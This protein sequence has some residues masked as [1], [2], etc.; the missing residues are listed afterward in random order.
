MGIKDEAPAPDRIR[1]A[2]DHRDAEAG[3]GGKVPPLKRAI[4]SDSI[5]SRTSRRN[6]IDVAAALPIQYRTV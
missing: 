3:K 2:G 5:A 1:W 6:S 4:S